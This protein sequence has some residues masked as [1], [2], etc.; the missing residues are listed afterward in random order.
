MM[1]LDIVYLML[2]WRHSTGAGH[3]SV[4]TLAQGLA[5]IEVVPILF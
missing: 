4:V 5:W 3:I 2:L 1:F